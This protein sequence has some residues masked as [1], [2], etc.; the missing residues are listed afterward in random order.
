[1]AA[2]RPLDYIHKATIGTIT[3]TPAAAIITGGSTTFTVSVLNSAPLNSSGLSA[4]GTSTSLN[5]SGS[6]GAGGITAAAGSSSGPVSGFSFSSTTV[7]T[8][9]TGSFTVNDPNADN[10]PQTGMVSVNVYGHAS[11][12]LSGTT[13]FFNA[14]AGSGSSQTSGTSILVSNASGHNINLAASGSNG[15]ITLTTLSGAT[16]VAAGT[17]ANATA[18]LAPGA[19]AGTFSVPVTYNFADDST[20]SGASSDGSATITVAGGIYDYANAVYS[21]TSMNFG[22]MHVGAT[23]SGSLT[24]AFGNQTITNA[25]YQDYL[26]VT[27]TT[28]NANLTTTGFTLLGAS[29]SGTTTSNLTV[30]VNTATAG[31]LNSTVTL[32]LISDATEAPGLANGTAT[33][34]GM[35]GSIT[36]S[37][38]VYSGLGVW[39]TNGSGSWGTLTGTGTST[40]GQNWGAN[41]G[42]PGLDPGF[43]NTDTATFDNT[44]LTTGG[45]ATVTLDGA[46]PSLMAITFN[47]TGGGGY[48]LAQGDTSVAAGVI[49]LS[50]NSGNATVTDLSGNHTISAPVSLTT[51]VNVNVASGQQITFSGPV[52]GTGSFNSTGSGAT[53]LTG[54]NTYSGGTTVSSGA[55]ILANTSGSATGTGAL[56]VTGT[57]TLA[58][59][60]SSS[61]TSFSI[62]GSGTTVPTRATVLVGQ[63]AAT[64]NTD[65]NT[66]STVLSLTASSTSTITNAN[67]VF[68]LSTVGITPNIQNTQNAGTGNELNFG[69][70]SSVLFSN[71][72][73]T[74]Y[75]QGGNIVPNT[76]EF[77]LFTSSTTGSGIGGSIFGGDLTLSGTNVIGGLTIS[78]GNEPGAGYYDTASYLK[79][80]S[81]GSG[82]NVVVEVVPEPGTWALM[83]GGLAMLVAGPFR[84]K[85]KQAC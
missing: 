51:G 75:L 74:L 32:N 11:P 25:A 48:T 71:T 30:S 82:Y 50:G 13:I 84:Q 78:F 20:L 72:T 77:T 42:S 7:G 81:N 33:V 38:M 64:A 9:V 69:A 8:A 65:T 3:S 52:S 44:A 6:I 29:T 15:S 37:G 58:G 16:G 47:T 19:T 66:T 12:S 67:L 31:S 80:V 73:L 68:N 79:L 34:V 23:P 43:T 70:T 57:G 18:T 63:N 24:V 55:L 1:M 46:S 17:G 49:S 10:T 5:V 2:A 21:G 53:V 56:S 62:T 35:P 22:T 14:R 4:S 26:D 28:G 59:T 41:Q 54:T 83:I 45:S 36:T 76:T 40:F 60:G 39:N 27:G 61:S 85:R